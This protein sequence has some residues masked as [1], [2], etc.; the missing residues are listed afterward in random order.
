MRCPSQHVLVLA[1][2]VAISCGPSRAAKGEESKAT[3]S[4]PARTEASPALKAEIEQRFAAI[5]RLDF[6][7][8]LLDY[9]LATPSFTTRR[10]LRLSISG[11][12]HGTHHGLARRR[13]RGTRGCGRDRDLLRALLPFG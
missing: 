6:R 7:A 8:T 5:E 13:R 10:A 12:N 3:T 2:V 4:E 9:R 11:A 1:T